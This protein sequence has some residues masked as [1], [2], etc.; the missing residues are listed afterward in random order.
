MEN[1][2]K[3]ESYEISQEFMHEYQGNFPP[4]EVEPVIKLSSEKTCISV[5]GN[6]KNWRADFRSH[7]ELLPILREKNVKSVFIPNISTFTGMLSYHQSYQPEGEIEGIEIF[8]G[9][10]S[11]GL[12]IPFGSAG[13]FCTAD[14]PTIVYHD[15][16]KD[17]VIG[18]HAGLG[19]VIDRN[20]IITGKPYRSDESIVD[21]IMW[22][23]EKKGSDHYEIFV[24]C[25]IN[26]HSFV[27]S[28][29]DL[30]YGVANYK[31]LN[32]LLKN[33]GDEAVPRGLKGGNISLY[34]IIRRQLINYGIDEDKIKTDDLD[35]FSNL[36]LWSHYRASKNGQ[37]GCGRNG[38][39][40]IHSA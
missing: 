5:F 2:S 13:F 22:Y 27:Y 1:L 37:N 15:I 26:Q 34:G 10:K 9:I 28:I 29:K 30:N 32:Y 31:L 40:V 36:N 19:S 24:I 23:K 38:I 12:A 20:K 11:E 25:G 6:A 35:T 16:E 17:I 4:P 21:Q 39:L 3:A 14:C 7:V 18:A 8:S 33:Y